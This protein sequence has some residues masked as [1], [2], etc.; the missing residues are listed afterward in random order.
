MS[1]EKVLSKIGLSYDNRRH[2]PLSAEGNHSD[3]CNSVW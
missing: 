1:N 3:T 2:W